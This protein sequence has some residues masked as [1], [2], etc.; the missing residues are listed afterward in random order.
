MLDGVLLQLTQKL[1]SS[2]CLNF[3]TFAVI[4]TDDEFS[5][6]NLGKTVTDY[7]NGHFWSRYWVASGANPDKLV[8]RFPMLAWANGP[9]N[10]KKSEAFD[11]PCFTGMLIIGVLPDCSYCPPGCKQTPTQA[12]MWQRL[13]LGSIMDSLTKLVRVEYH[14][15]TYAWLYY[16]QY[17][18]AKA[19]NEVKCIVDELDVSYNEARELD[20]TYNGGIY[21]GAEVTIC[22]CVG[23]LEL[24][25]TSLYPV[26]GVTKCTL[27]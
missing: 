9:V 2:D 14:N 7:K 17:Q 23:N 5:S 8:A 10:Y 12:R 19:A 22:K 6:P 18:A 11:G 27:C 24:Q 16:S 25:Q 3:D 26:T 21:L 1:A 15:G 20:R 4:N 13:M